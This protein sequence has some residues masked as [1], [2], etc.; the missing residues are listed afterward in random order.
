VEPD[1]GSVGQWWQMSADAG[2]VG[3]RMTDGSVGTAAA[4]GRRSE[5]KK[6]AVLAGQ[7]TNQSVKKKHIKR[8]VVASSQRWR[9]G[10][11]FALGMRA[12]R[13]QLVNCA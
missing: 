10:D 13:R 2:S 3:Q 1:A 11:T 8:M 12:K 5:K 9:G 6:M 4:A 7:S